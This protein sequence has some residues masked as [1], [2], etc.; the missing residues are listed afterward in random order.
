MPRYL[1]AGDIGGTN[2]RLELH[3]SDGDVSRVLLEQSFPSQAYATFETLLDD[4]L[5]LEP[6]IGF[7]RRIDAACFS[8]AGPVDDNKAQLTNLPWGLDGDALAAR[9]GVPEVLVINDFAAVGHGIGEL[10]P[11]DVVTLQR[12]TPEPEASRVAVGA[13]TGL[14]VCAMTPRNRRYAVHASEAGHVD[15]A[16][17]NAMQDALLA[18]LRAELGHVSY[19]R[20]VSGPGLLRIFDFLCER[21]G[22]PSAELLEV[23]RREDPSAAISQ[24]ALRGRD[25][26]ATD[27]LELFVEIYGAFCGNMALT[28]IAHGGVYIAGG[29]ARQ[30][31]PKLEDGRFIRAFTAKGR[32]SDLLSRCPVHVVMDAKVGLKG[33]L[34]L[35]RR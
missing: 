6:T 28:M 31:V 33:A 4:F 20:V 29:I 19:E 12:G 25:P 15:F 16:P 9:Y 26:L 17:I 13:G 21:G 8:V 24:F 11:H 2:A 30:I 35:I 32:F 7:A 18:S 5:Q 23:M 14:G 1:L 10:G 27:A 22:K 34:S 3:E